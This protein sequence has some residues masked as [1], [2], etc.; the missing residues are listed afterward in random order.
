MEQFVLVLVSV[1]NER[2]TTQSATDHELP[3]YH[4][5]QTPTVQ[6]SSFK[7]EI[8]KELFVKKDSLVD[9]FCV[10]HVSSSELRKFYSGKVQN[11]EFHCQILCNN[12]ISRRRYISDSEFESECS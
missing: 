1:Y 2:L 7:K 5:F 8:N 10:V 11:L 3:K 12:F 4:P 9:K 6:I